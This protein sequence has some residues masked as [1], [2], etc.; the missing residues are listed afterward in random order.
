MKPHHR[1]GTI[2]LGLVL[3]SPGVTWTVGGRDRRKSWRRMP[4]GSSAP[5]SSAPAAPE[6]GPA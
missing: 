5:S 1:V 3:F 6:G 4:T 2:L